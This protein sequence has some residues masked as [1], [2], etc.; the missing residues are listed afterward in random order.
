MVS[1]ADCQ[2]FK[3]GWFVLRV[4]LVSLNSYQ[5]YYNPSGKQPVIKNISCLRYI[6]VATDLEPIN[7]IKTKAKIRCFE[8]VCEKLHNNLSGI[9][10]RNLKKNE[11]N[12]GLPVRTP[13]AGG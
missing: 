8:F 2:I 9:L 3:P 7:Q 1:Q 5:R 11:K 4:C 12:S 13:A 10:Q 6:E